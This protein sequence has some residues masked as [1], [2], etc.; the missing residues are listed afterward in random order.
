MRYAIAMLLGLMLAGC[1]G[2]ECDAPEVRCLEADQQ[3]CSGSGQWV[4]LGACPFGRSCAVEEIPL[5]SG[6]LFTVCR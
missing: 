5:H 1:G 6:Q 2:T 4:S 3:A